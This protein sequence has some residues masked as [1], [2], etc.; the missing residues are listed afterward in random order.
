MKE[1][2][3]YSEP[4]YKS[5]YFSKKD[6]LKT[7]QAELNEIDNSPLTKQERAQK[8]TDFWDR[9][10]VYKKEYAYSVLKEEAARRKEFWDDLCEDLC[11]GRF[12]EETVK[13]IKE[14][15][16][17]ED[18]HSDGYENLYMRISDLVDLLE[19]TL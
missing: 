1:F 13:K 17:S 14:F 8:M 11:L 9:Y 10:E 5:T 18:W 15:S 12:K 4:E 6:W 7:H 2:K 3:Y 16:Q 19:T